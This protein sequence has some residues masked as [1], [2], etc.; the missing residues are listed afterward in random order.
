MVLDPVQGVA[1]SRRIGDPGRHHS[2]G[3]SAADCEYDSCLTELTRI[4]TKRSREV[5]KNRAH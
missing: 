4:Q 5:E 3:Q 1:D 2:S